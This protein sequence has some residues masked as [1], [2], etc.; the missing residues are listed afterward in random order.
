[1]AMA[2]E[3]VRAHTFQARA[4]SRHWASVGWALVAT[5][6]VGGV[7]EEPVGVLDQH[8]RPE[9]AELADQRLGGGG[10]QQTG[11]LALRRELGQ[12]VSS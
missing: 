6:H 7:D 12:A 9:A 3:V 2:L 4:R 8:A 1:M 5:C 10:R 11:G